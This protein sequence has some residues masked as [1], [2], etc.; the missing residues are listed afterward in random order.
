MGAKFKWVDM[1]IEFD[2]GLFDQISDCEFFFFADDVEVHKVTTAGFLVDSEKFVDGDVCKRINR[3]IFVLIWWC[4]LRKWI[5]GKLGF[6]G[7]VRE[8]EENKITVESGIN[9]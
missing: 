8:F 7:V 6:E 2:F 1:P 9:V 3:D 4:I 5:V